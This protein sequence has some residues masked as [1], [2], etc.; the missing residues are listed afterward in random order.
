MTKWGVNGIKSPVPRFEAFCFACCLMRLKAIQRTFPG[1]L[2]WRSTL[3]SENDPP[4]FLV[5]NHKQGIEAWE[6]AREWI[7]EIFLKG[8]SPS[9]M[10]KYGYGTRNGSTKH[11]KSL[12][13]VIFFPLLRSS[14]L[15]KVSDLVILIAKMHL[16]SYSTL[17]GSIDL[18]YMAALNLLDATSKYI[19]NIGFVTD[20]KVNFEP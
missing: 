17:A 2:D 15:S 12:S 3:L 1:Y 16:A 8:S 18:N 20:L 5:R 6:L 4:L 13:K 11:Y 10:Q 7:L 9:N 14:T 19:K